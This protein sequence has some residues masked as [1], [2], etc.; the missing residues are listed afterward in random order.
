MPKHWKLHLE[1]SQRCNS[2]R[3]LHP[4]RHALKRNATLSRHLRHPRRGG[5]ACIKRIALRLE[6]GQKASVSKGWQ[7]GQKKMRRLAAVSSTIRVSQRRQG[8]LPRANTQ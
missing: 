8:S 5:V 4:I 7:T 6:A 3:S 1:A 2:H